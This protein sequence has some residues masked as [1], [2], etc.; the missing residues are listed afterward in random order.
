MCKKSL[1]CNVQRF[2]K[3]HNVRKLAS[4]E[5]V[6]GVGLD[7]VRTRLRYDNMVAGETGSTK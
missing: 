6:E 3:R 5:L 7:S 4:I 1:H 2:A